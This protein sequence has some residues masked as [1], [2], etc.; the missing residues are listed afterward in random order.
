VA[1]TLPIP[2][3]RP[4]QSFLLVGGATSPPPRPERDAEEGKSNL[5]VVQ[6][7]DLPCSSPPSPL[8]S[9]W[10]FKLKRMERDH[11][12]GT[13]MISNQLSGILAQ[14]LQQKHQRKLSQQMEEGKS[15][16]EAAGDMKLSEDFSAIYLF[17][18]PLLY[19]RSILPPSSPPL[20]LC[21]SLSHCC[22]GRAVELAIVLNSLYLSLWLINFI[23]VCARV[24]LTTLAACHVSPPPL[25]SLMVP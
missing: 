11:G 19:F 13:G 16:Q 2:K 12:R 22:T 9:P 5:N 25:P 4:I 23:T 14:S 24:R 15:Q 6:Q 18:S 21:I 7:V 3:K 17:Q 20:L 1:S 10:Q 8:S